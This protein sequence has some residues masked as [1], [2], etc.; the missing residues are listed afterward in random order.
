MEVNPREDADFEV[1][2]HTIIVIDRNVKGG[3]KKSNVAFW[4]L[5]V[6]VCCC[7]CARRITRVLTSAVNTRTFVNCARGLVTLSTRMAGSIMCTIGFFC[8]PFPCQPVLVWHTWLSRARVGTWYTHTWYLVGLETGWS[9]CC[10]YVSCELTG[11]LTRPLLRQFKLTA[12]D[13][14]IFCC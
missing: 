9:A 7:C 14:Y 2:T 1:S 5:Y 3:A 13:I 4:S 8:V 11:E 12:A 10:A 6:R